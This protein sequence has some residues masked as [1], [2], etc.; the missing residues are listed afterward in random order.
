[1]YIHVYTEYRG[2][3]TRTSRQ[4]T[5]SCASKVKEV[6]QRKPFFVVSKGKVNK[7]VLFCFEE[8]CHS[9]LKELN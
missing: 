1:M 9:H 5:F 8:F 6:P 3:L 4:G 2:T 7:S